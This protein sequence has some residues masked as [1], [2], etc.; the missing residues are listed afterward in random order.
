ML[1]NTE[2]TNKYNWLFSV[3][4]TGSVV[5]NESLRDRQPWGKGCW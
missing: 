1:Q 2:I 5:K 3:F 4:S